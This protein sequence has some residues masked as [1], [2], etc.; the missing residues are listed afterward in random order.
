MLVVVLI[1]FLYYFVMCTEM[2]TYGAPTWTTLMIMNV[3]KMTDKTIEDEDSLF[4]GTG[5]SVDA[6]DYFAILNGED[7]EKTRA[8]QQEHM[9]DGINAVQNSLNEESKGNYDASA[10]LLDSAIQNFKIAAEMALDNPEEQDGIMKNVKMYELKKKQLEQKMRTKLDSKT[11]S[12]MEGDYHPS[13]A[14]TPFTK[15]ST[16]SWKSNPDYPTSQQKTDSKRNQHQ[17]Y[18]VINWGNEKHVIEGLDMEK[19]II[20]T[21]I[22]DC[23][24]EWDFGKTINSG[25]KT[26]LLSNPNTLLLF[27]PSGNGKTLLV[28]QLAKSLPNTSFFSLAAPNLENQ[29]ESKILRI[30]QAMF[31]IPLKNQSKSKSNHTPTILFFDDFEYILT[32]KQIQAKY[33]ESILHL[34]NKKSNA[35]IICA[36]SKPWQIPKDVLYCFRHFV[37]VDF[38][39]D[40][41]RLKLCQKL[42][43]I[44]SMASY[45]DKETL[46]IM[47]KLTC[48]YSYRAIVQTLRSAVKK[49]KAS[50][51]KQPREADLLMHFYYILEQDYDQHH[52][53]ALKMKYNDFMTELKTMI[54][55]DAKQ[56]K[57]LNKEQHEAKGNQQKNENYYMGKQPLKGVHLQMLDSIMQV[58]HEEV[59]KALKFALGM[60]LTLRDPDEISL[61][62]S[63]EDCDK[64]ITNSK[65]ITDKIAELSS[66]ISKKNVK[67]DSIVGSSDDTASEEETTSQTKVNTSYVAIEWN[68]F[69]HFLNDQRK[70][71]EH[72]RR[73]NMT[74]KEYML[75][76]RKIFD[77]VDRYGSGILDTDN[78]CMALR[79]DVNIHSLFKPSLMNGI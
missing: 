19:Q 12:Q 6:N 23:I 17:K 62:D 68:G 66:I 43:R 20:E 9:R 58:N 38:P 74:E 33:I 4:L 69:W 55:F 3:A 65:Q 77:S 32:S 64:I 21:F 39:P 2:W 13:P 47:M 35:I 46:E 5:T 30:L 63:H 48:G 78:F 79:F 26:K 54:D 40:N 73:N 27:G 50:L 42:R 61:E 57:D 52:Q 11:M 75:T 41:I 14:K 31:R 49:M 28:K 37:M 44:P 60:K 10:T 24:G 22:N 25:N 51:R 53:L 15:S 70:K 18:L 29:T 36:S 67:S 7:K 56:N 34:A 1:S 59:N 72:D 71:Y 8:V 76:A 45:A 16:T